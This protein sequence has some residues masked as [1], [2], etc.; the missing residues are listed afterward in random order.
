MQLIITA[1]KDTYITNKIINN[2]FR[3]ENANIGHAST[4]DLFKLYEESGLVVDGELI[5]SD[6]SEDSILFVKFDLDKI[7]SLTSSILNFSNSNFKASVELQDISSG[8][9]KPFDFSAI[10][11]PLAKKFDEGNGFDVNTFSDIGSANYLTSSFPTSTPILWQTPGAKS[12]GGD[13]KVK[14]TGNITAISQVG[15]DNTATF[16]ISDGSN[17]VTFTANAA[18]ATP[19][20]S[21]IHI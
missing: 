11:N 5:T 3:S 4:L 16:A 9:Q 1:S 12:G 20:L 6:I 2:E 10:C 17:T 13:G 14:A 7:G 15:L 19:A 8:L 21:L 18:S